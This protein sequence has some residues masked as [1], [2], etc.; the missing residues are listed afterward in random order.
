MEEYTGE[1]LVYIINTAKKGQQELLT[2][3]RQGPH[4]NRHGKSQNGATPGPRP[5]TLPAGAD[6]TGK[7]KETDE[8]LPREAGRALGT[9][10]KGSF[11][12]EKAKSSPLCCGP[13]IQRWHQEA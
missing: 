10:R 6:R 9:V 2:L 7:R 4:R 8:R 12:P 3:A 11:K 13:R 5:S 1:D